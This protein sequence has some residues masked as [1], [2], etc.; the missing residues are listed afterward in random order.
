MTN[1][2]ILLQA[3]LGK[4]PGVV[5]MATTATDTLY[6]GAAGHR[7]AAGMVAMT[8]DTIFGLASM[9]KAV[10]SVAALQEI[11][12]GRLSLDAPIAEVL[13]A[14][15]APMVLEGFADDGTPRLRPAVGAITLRQ[16]LSHSAG[17]GYDT[18]NA[19]I[20]RFHTAAK[21]PRLP[22]SPAELARIPLLFDPGTAWNYGIN[23]DIVGLAVEAA[24]GKR[25]DV[26]LADGVCGMLGMNETGFEV[27]AERRARMATTRT[28][29][30]N[31]TLGDAGFPMDRGIRYCMGGGGLQGTGRDYLRFIRMVLN[32]GMHEGTRV[33]SPAMM[34][35]V[36]RNQLAPGV[37]V[38]R[39]VSGN[40]ARSNDAEFFPGMEKHWS[41]AFM[42][43]AEPAPTGRNA[44]SLAW[45]GIANTY[46]W[47]DQKAGVG[48][49]FMA[50]LLPFADPAVLDGFAA[51]ERAVY[52]LVTRQ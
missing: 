15:A 14:L 27:P 16:L 45:A 33:L 34:A 23:T 24:S 42:I 8:T 18:W 37:R 11:D 5:A 2:D 12:A 46:C 39:M 50:Q 22:E 13:P 26:A 40:P 35:E 43:N 48:G 31:G 30:P 25:L 20:A 17:F 51:F 1:L 47:I 28:R 29:A 19:E 38:R 36:A 52:E 3:Q 6:E 21:I 10:V 41:A 4:V 44:G 7:D 49:V 32:G 9:T